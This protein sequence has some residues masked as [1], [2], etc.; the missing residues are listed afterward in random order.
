MDRFIL[1]EE[2]KERILTLHESAT[3]RHYLSEQS[4]KVYD[5]HDKSYDYKVSNDKWFASKKGLNKWFSI[6]K[7]SNSTSKLDKKYPSA[8]KS[9]SN[10][11]PKK[12]TT[13]VKDKLVKS[14][15]SN[16]K[17]GLDYR[18]WLNDNF[19]NTASK[20]AV[21]PPSKLG[22]K[23]KNTKAFYSNNN[24][25]SSLNFSLKWSSGT[26]KGKEVSV[27]KYYQLKNPN[28]GKK[29]YKEKIEAGVYKIPNTIPNADRL[30]KELYYI[31]ARPKYNGKPF[32]MVDPRLNL[33]LAFDAKHKLVDYSQ[34]VAG[35]DKQKDVLFTRK[36]WCESS[37]K[38]NSFKNFKGYEQ[39]IRTINGKVHTSIESYAD[40][41]VGYLENIYKYNMLSKLKARYAQKGIYGISNKYFQKGYQ[42][43]KG[44]PNSFGLEKDGISVGTA[45][46]ALVPIESRI[47]ADA[48]LQKLLQKD[49]NS[50]TIPK[51][52]IDM[53]EKDFLSSSKSKR[54][55]KSSGCFNV[56]PK[57]IQDSKVQK[58]FNYP[59]VPVFIMGEQDTDYLVQVEPG[60]EGEFMLDL[61]GKD[62]KCTSPTGLSNTYGTQ[63][64]L[65]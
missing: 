6:E 30:N 25:V 54:F 20:Y 46:H 63:V 40:E 58:V 31:N 65:A 19:P 24:I 17:Q 50:G 18:K 42:G 45:I 43:E 33:V 11:A 62:G 1:G 27:W 12:N 3:K 22:E 38:D 2:E 13:D 36:M 37:H 15:F 16:K 48:E 7:Y 61:G 8:R 52:Y 35:A 60:K 26:N 56:D 10:T 51:E 47:T 39:C 55:D 29:T 28:W 34:T 5:N 9:N 44:T 64:G 53:V 57:F 21:D 41:K 23:F 4:D 32:V 14:P 59:G 49:L